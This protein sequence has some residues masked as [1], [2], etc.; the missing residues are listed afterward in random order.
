[1]R[2]GFPFLTE[3]G[4]TT[5]QKPHYFRRRY[6]VS[7]SLSLSLSLFLCLS[8]ALYVFC[9]IATPLRTFLRRKKIYF[10]GQRKNDLMDELGITS[11]LSSPYHSSSVASSF[12]LVLAMERIHNSLICDERANSEMCQGWIA[13][14]IG[15][16]NQNAIGHMNMWCPQEKGNETAALNHPLV[17]I[18]ASRCLCNKEFPSP[19]FFFLL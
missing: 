10:R 2:Q 5:K 6:V 19:L 7:L 11:S 13:L 3:K 17:S 18:Y 14:R 15:R 9:S 4:Q 8:P 1:M 16:V 12:A